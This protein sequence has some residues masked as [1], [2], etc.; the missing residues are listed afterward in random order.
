MEQI[1]NTTVF[2][3]KKTYYPL[4]TSF[5]NRRSLN[6]ILFLLIAAS[7]ISEAILAWNAQMK[8]PFHTGTLLF[9]ILAGIVSLGF[10]LFLNFQIKGKSDIDKGVNDEAKTV[11]SS[12][13]SSPKSLYT[14]DDNKFNA[15]LLLQGLDKKRSVA[16]FAEALIKNINNEFKI[17]QAVFYVKK[18]EQRFTPA[19]GFAISKEFMDSSFIPGEGVN[20]QAALDGKVKIM[21]VIPENYRLIK[22][23]LGNGSPSYISIIPFMHEK[24]CIGMLEFSAFQKRTAEKMELLKIL[25]VSVG[26]IL[27]K[28]IQKK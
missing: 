21:S 15:S 10:L 14:T 2:I 19:A 13:S 18:D 4:E 5:L 25:S 12:D 28:I 27:F 26:Q 3:K 16:D 23:G 22:S 20:G 9:W 17:V 1:P 7:I 24:E 8:I 6:I 11:V